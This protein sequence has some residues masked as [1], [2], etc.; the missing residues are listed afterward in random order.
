MQPKDFILK[1]PE[2][3]KRLQKKFEKMAEELQRQ[4]AALGKPHPVCLTATGRWGGRRLQHMPSHL[5]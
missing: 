3:D 4:K 2:N 1:T 5:E